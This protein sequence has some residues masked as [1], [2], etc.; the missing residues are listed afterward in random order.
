MSHWRSVLNA[1]YEGWHRNQRDKATRASS[2]ASGLF[3][4]VLRGSW[5]SPFTCH[6]ATCTRPSR[7]RPRSDT[8]L[9]GRKG[10]EG[11][12]AL[13]LPDCWL[14]AEPRSLGRRVLYPPM[15]HT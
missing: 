5:T 6:R 9:T 14:E 3:P 11:G 7:Q 4:A 1:A 2:V 13:S 10:P 15:V 8:W 12:Q